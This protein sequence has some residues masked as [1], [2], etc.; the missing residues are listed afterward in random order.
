MRC[1]FS[2]A[3][4]RMSWL[5]AQAEADR[6]Q[7]GQREGKQQEEDGAPVQCGDHPAADDRGQDRRQ[8]HDQDQRGKGARRFARAA[9][10]A[11]HGAGDDHAGGTAQRLQHAPGGEGGDVVGQRAAERR[12]REQRQPGVQR[13]LA[14]EAVGQRPPDQLAAGHADEEAGQREFGAAGGRGQIPLQRRERGQIHVDRER[15]DGGQRAEDDQ[16]AGKAARV[17][18]GLE[19]HGW[20]KQRWRGRLPACF[21]FF[22]AARLPADR[23]ARASGGPDAGGSAR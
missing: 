19:V 4:W 12:Q 17:Q 15:A 14:A 7:A 8:A 5:S 13:R 23:A 16:P 22:A 21:S 6:Q 2:G 9:A 11:H 20:P 10:V 1:A 3:S 18:A